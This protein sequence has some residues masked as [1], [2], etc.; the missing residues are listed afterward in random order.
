MESSNRMTPVTSFIV[1]DILERAMEME[2]DGTDVVHLEVGEPDFAPPPAVVES[3]C[4]AARDGHT[5]YTHSLGVYA[6]REAIADWYRRTY[7]VS[8]DPERVIVTPGT[9]GAFL[10]AI[11]VLLDPGDK[12]L[13]T[14]PGYPCY[15]NF[16]RLL[17]V[18]PYLLPIEAA[19]GFIPRK[20]C[21][22][23]AI[24]QGVK[25]VLLASPANPTGALMDPDL[26]RWL[27]ALPVPFISDEIYHGL[28]YSNEPAHSALEYADDVMVIN[29]LSKRLA[30]TGLRIGWAIVPKNLVRPFQKL[31][32][33]LFICA[34]SISQQAAITALTDPS[35]DGAV[36]SMVQT[37]DRRRK[38]L[39]DGLTKIGFRIHYEPRGAFYV[40]ADISDFSR[41]GYDFAYRILREARVACTP[42]IDFGRNQTDH[43]LRFAYTVEESRIREGMARIARLLGA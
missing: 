43:F 11:A 8:V 2:R 7:G 3:L 6:L 34:D 18:E 41:D 14:D 13:L 19:D 36:A 16:A 35:V 22:L 12:L 10:N 25:T 39:I 20:D 29:G 38:A 15:P 24:E 30:M 33:N 26:L 27:T 21:I 4:R 9:S 32:Q 17:S 28:V 23:H 42:G 5:H 40:F 1:M 31:N 37:Y